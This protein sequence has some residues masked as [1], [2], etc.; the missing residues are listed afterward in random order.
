MAGPTFI[1]GRC[2]AAEPCLLLRSCQFSAECEFFLTLVDPGCFLDLIEGRV[3]D[4]SGNSDVA[5]V[6]EEEALVW[7]SC[8]LVSSPACS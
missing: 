7:L 6:V 2:L 5:V 3:Q 1:L 8:R 4:V